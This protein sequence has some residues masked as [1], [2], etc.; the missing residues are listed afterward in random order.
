[1]GDELSAEEEKDYNWGYTQGLEAARE[2]W[3]EWQCDDRKF[4]ESIAFC[5][6]FDEGFEEGRGD[7]Q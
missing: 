5:D 6:G 4:E 2:K 7:A 1:M 3:Q